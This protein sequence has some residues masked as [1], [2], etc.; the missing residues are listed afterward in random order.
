MQNIIT[1][2]Y[3]FDKNLRVPEIVVYE[4]ASFNGREF[5]T[6]LFI[7]DLGS[8]TRIYTPAGITGAYPYQ[9]LAYNVWDMNDKISAIVVVSGI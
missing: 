1:M 6:N 5:R 9:T 7:N 2:E 8:R 4:H 3:T